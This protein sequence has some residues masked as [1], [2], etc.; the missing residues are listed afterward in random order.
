[1]TNL[2][3]LPREELP[4]FEAFF[5]STESKAGYLPTAYLVLGHQ[6]AFLRAM[7]GVS[8]AMAEMQ[9]VDTD[10]KVLMSHLSSGAAGCQFC[11]A[12][13]A[14]RANAI[15]VNDAKLLAVWEFETSPLFSEAE[16]AALRLALNMVARP[17]GVTPALF[18]DLREHF[19]EA[20]IA[21]LVITV[22]MFGFWNRWNDSLATQLEAPVHEFASALLSDRGWDGSRHQHDESAKEPMP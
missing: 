6:P 14:Q 11:E 7:I 10:L 22:S 15:G 21:E 9:S 2:R 12:H 16:R 18:D 3:P 13:T 17:N 5:A 8:G 19:D 20:Q 4:E 1:M